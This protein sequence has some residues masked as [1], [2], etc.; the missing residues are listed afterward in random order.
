MLYEATRSGA[1]TGVAT[2]ATGAACAA[3]LRT[4]PAGTLTGST[5]AASAAAPASQTRDEHVG[6]GRRARRPRSGREV[7][8]IGLLRGP[9]R[10]EA[11]R[12]GSRVPA[13]RDGASTA[14]CP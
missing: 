13:H 2:V 3:G 8:V 9:D 12:A 5:R 4:D 11:A 7:G 10:R 14:V 1:E 6:R